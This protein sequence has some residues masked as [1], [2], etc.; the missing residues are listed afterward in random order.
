M[1]VTLKLKYGT[2]PVSV[3]FAKYASN[4]RTALLFVHDDTSETPASIN[5][6]HADVPDADHI[7]VKSYSENEGMDKE[8][9]RLG[10]IQPVPVG[11]VNSG[12][13]TAPIHKLTPQAIALRDKQFQA[14]GI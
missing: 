3:Q 5:I 1:E 8:L 7:V 14:V 13:I 2:Y 11:F 10:L 12:F 6:S 4:N 9:V